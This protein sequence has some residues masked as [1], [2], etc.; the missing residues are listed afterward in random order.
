MGEILCFKNAPLPN[1]DEPIK[2]VN[3]VIF[4]KKYVMLI[5]VQS[6]NLKLGPDAGKTRFGKGH[7][8]KHHKAYYDNFIKK[9]G[10]CGALQ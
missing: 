8:G 9:S 7:Y 1:G 6:T 2:S 5:R 3:N 4:L 10:K